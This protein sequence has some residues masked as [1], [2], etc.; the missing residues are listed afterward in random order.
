MQRAGVDLR[1]I[2]YPGAKH[3]F[4]NSATGLYAKLGLDIGYNTQADKKSW[5][6]M[7]RLFERILSD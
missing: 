6:D 3:G 7:K 4:I 5:Q 2:I 1:I